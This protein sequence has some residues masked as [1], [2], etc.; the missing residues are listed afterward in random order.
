MTRPPERGWDPFK[1]A[2]RVENFAFTDGAFRPTGIVHGFAPKARKP[3]YYLMG[4]GHRSLPGKTVCERGCI[5]SPNWSLPVV[6][7]P[8]LDPFVKR[9]LRARGV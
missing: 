6:R 3:L 9:A 5:E 1:D 4:C 8:E 7:H 2:G